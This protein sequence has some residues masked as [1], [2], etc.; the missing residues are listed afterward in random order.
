MGGSNVTAVLAFWQGLPPTQMR[1][2]VHMA[3][4]AYDPPGK[5]GQA[6]CIYWGADDNQA[7]ALGYPAGRKSN[8]RMLQKLR[9]KLLAAGALELVS[10]GSR[11][12]PTRWFVNTTPP[13]WRPAKGVT[14]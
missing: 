1:L 5:D 7:Q 14:E 8:R 4:T 6:P 9:A 11:T 12:E 2:L 13:S 10:R 3:V